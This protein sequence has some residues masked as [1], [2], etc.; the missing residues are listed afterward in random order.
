MA[1]AQAHGIRRPR[2]RLRRLFFLAE[3][4]FLRAAEV[5]FTLPFSSR[6]AGRLGSIPER[7]SRRL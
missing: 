2:T 3:R 1:G 6:P 4:L 7:R 5:L